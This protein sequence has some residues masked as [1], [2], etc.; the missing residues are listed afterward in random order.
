MVDQKGKLVPGLGKSMQSNILPLEN[1]KEGWDV[2]QYEINDLKG[3]TPTR[4]AI[5]P[6]SVPVRKAGWFSNETYALRRKPK[7]EGKSTAITRLR[8]RQI[9]RINTRLC[10]DSLPDTG[11]GKRNE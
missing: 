7:T 3:F 9:K 2:Y 5:F 4:T 10:G 11:R 6:V 1:W 8:H